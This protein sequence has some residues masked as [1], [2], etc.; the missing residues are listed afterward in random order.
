G[1]NTNLPPSNGIEYGDRATSAGVYGVLA[2]RVLDSYDHVP[3]PSYV[4]VIPADAHGPK[5]QPIEV[6]TDGMGYFMVRDRQPPQHY[7]L[8]A[9]PREGGPRLAGTTWATPPNP[10]VLIYMSQDLA[11]PNT[12]PPPGPPAVSGQKNTPTQSNSEGNNSEPSR[13]QSKPSTSSI[14]Q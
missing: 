8:V 1:T 5:G 3:P 6:E 10:R 4:K 12:P 9:R 11:T 14:P 2:G 7:Q 13:E